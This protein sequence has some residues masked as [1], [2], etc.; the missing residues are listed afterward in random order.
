[1]QFLFFL[2]AAAAGGLLM[3]AI[4][5]MGHAKSMIQQWATLYGPQNDSPGCT[6][7]DLPCVV[8]LT[9]DKAAQKWAPMCTVAQGIRF[10]CL[11]ILS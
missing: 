10:M 5:D 3:I 8:A 2:A 9:V 1:M 4:S 7:G 6:R 11:V